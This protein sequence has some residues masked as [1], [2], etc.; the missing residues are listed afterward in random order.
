[1]V[2]RINKSFLLIFSGL[3]VFYLLHFIVLTR[4]QYKFA[5]IFAEYTEVPCLIH[6]VEC[7]NHGHYNIIK[8]DSSDSTVYEA[9]HSYATGNCSEQFVGKEVIAY[10]SKKFPDSV[11]YLEPKRVI[12]GF[13]TEKATNWIGILF[14]GIP[15]YILA[16][17]QIKKGY[18]SYFVFEIFGK[19]K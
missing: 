6:K 2:I 4:Q 15:F 17:L 10:F 11:S 13:K 12:Q 14:L 1:M 16:Y 18:A 9:A 3:V 19:K 5:T 8:K 7:Q